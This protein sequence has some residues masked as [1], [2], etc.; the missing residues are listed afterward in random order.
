[1]LEVYTRVVKAVRYAMIAYGGGKWI[2]A[3]L[4]WLIESRITDKR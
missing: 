1:M 4:E 3:E 2:R